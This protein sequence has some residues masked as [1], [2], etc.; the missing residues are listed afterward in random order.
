M[1]EFNSESLELLAEVDPDA[2]SEDQVLEGDRLLYISVLPAP[3]DTQASQTTSQ[4]LAEAHQKHVGTNTE[5]PEHLQDFSDMF[6][7]E[8]FDALLKRKVWDHAIKLE[9]GSKPANCKVYPLSP[10]EQSELDAFL[11]EN[12]WSGHI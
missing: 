8:S 12:L 3:E 6:S 9:P 11:Q 1:P 4:R 5:I 10:N 7:K 2:S